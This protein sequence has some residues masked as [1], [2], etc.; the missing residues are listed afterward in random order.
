MWAPIDIDSHPAPR[1][2]TLLVPAVVSIND[3]RFASLGIERLEGASLASGFLKP[4]SNRNATRDGFASTVTGGYSSLVF[5]RGSLDDGAWP[6]GLTRGLVR[7][8]LSGSP[9]HDEIALPLTEA[10]R[11]LK[12]RFR[13][14]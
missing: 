5:E 12:K 2:H 6:V 8:E 10:S 7:M 14:C 3:T 11:G 4:A 1:D 9:Q 13:I